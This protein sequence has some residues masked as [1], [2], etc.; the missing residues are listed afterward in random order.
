MGSIVRTWAIVGLSSASDE[1]IWQFAK[2]NGWI[3]VSKDDDFQILANRRGTP[4]QVVWV[5]LGNCRKQVLLDA[6]VKVLPELIAAAQSG[7]SVIEVR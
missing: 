5:R 6:F 2:E 3:I 7:S 1:A 4:P